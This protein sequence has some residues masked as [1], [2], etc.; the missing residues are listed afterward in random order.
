MIIRI[1]K[2]NLAIAVPIVLIIVLAIAIV[3]IDKVFP[4]PSA[5]E[6]IKGIA[7]LSNVTI[8]IT[9]FGTS[10]EAKVSVTDFSDFQCPACRMFS[11]QFNAL[12]E[13]Y[14]DQVNF[15]F[16]HFPINSDSFM[17]AEASEC[18]RDQGKFWE[19]HDLLF[20]NPGKHTAMSLSS[21][22]ASLGLKVE[23]FGDCLGTREKNEKV[24]NDFRMGQQL[25]ITGTPTIIINGMLFEGARAFD[26]LKGIID[27]ELEDG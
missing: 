21:M 23:Q 26:E 10:P 24:N 17:I 1:K 4:T 22:A 20:E 12:M 15:E 27:R 2:D 13:H 25:G 11:G 8:N 6:K 9:S 19:Y 7:R 5:A 16:R 18:A 3:N 14:G